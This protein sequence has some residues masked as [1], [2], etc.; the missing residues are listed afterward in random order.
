MQ[1]TVHARLP[2][3][4]A[5]RSHRR[6]SIVTRYPHRPAP[7]DPPSSPEPHRAAAD[8]G[9]SACLAT[10][11]ARHRCCSPPP[12]A[13]PLS[14]LS[15]SLPR[16]PHL[17]PHPR[18]QE[19]PCARACILSKQHLPP[20]RRQASGLL[21]AGRA[22][23]YAERRGRRCVRKPSRPLELA[24]RGALAGPAWHGVWAAG[25]R[26]PGRALPAERRRRCLRCSCLRTLTHQTLFLTSA[27]F[28]SQRVWKRQTGAKTDRRGFTGCLVCTDQSTH[29]RELPV[30]LH[31]PALTPQGVIG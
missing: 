19:A 18:G 8:A 26:A 11:P 12:C 27:R 9:V 4:S 16:R 23:R 20:M 14:K 1:V 6:T 15:P 31:G 22:G 5:P 29:P 13:A 24:R 2:A 7:Y 17:G 25:S 30:A 21:L 10:R 28:Q 3:P